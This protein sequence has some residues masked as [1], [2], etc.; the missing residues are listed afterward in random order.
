MPISR[1]DP[2]PRLLNFIWEKDPKSI[3]DIGIGFGAM[4][5]LFRQICDIRWG[6]VQHWETIIH[7]IEIHD[8]YLN[9]IWQYA[10]NLV[11]IGEAIEQLPTM[12]KDYDLVFLGDVLEHLEKDRAK[13]LLDMC[14]EKAKKWVII[15]TPAEF[16][17]N[18]EEARRF[19][20]PYEEHKCLLEDKDFPEGSIIER[21]G[22]QKIII[23]EK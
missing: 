15:T 18:E 21:Y 4:G 8:K 17:S 16:H 7:G 20:N 2:L 12:D 1:P 13:K 14:I 23:I 22:G 19:G 6:R 10:Y 5:V 11:R 9:P 3:L